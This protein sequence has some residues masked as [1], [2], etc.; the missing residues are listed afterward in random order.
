MLNLLF[1][2]I[3]MVYWLVEIKVL[4]EVVVEKDI[5]VVFDEIYEKIIYDDV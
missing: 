5:L 4:V 1:N 2:L 3:G